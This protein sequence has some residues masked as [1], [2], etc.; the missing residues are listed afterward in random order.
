MARFQPVTFTTKDGAVLRGRPGEP[1]DAAALA[2]FRLHSSET[3]P[4]TVVLPGESTRSI[5]DR[6]RELEQTLESPGCYLLVVEYDQP[7]A[8]PMIVGE[9]SFNSHPLK[10]VAHHGHLGMSIHAAWRGRGLGQAMMRHLLDWA[11]DHPVIEKVCLGVL[12]ENAHAI[13]LYKKMG[14]IEECRRDREF[15]FGPGRY[16]DDIQM[17]LWVKPPDDGGPPGRARAAER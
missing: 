4:Y 10:R 1:A 9:L 13:A 14:F 7:G 5:A 3:S 15:K 11:R 17:S 8:G 16:I 2:A 12:A 6:T